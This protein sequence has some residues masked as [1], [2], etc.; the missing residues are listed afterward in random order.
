MFRMLNGEGNPRADSTPHH[1]PA[2]VP[3]EM[4]HIDTTGQFQESRGGS[5]Y[6]IIFVV[7]AF[8]FQSPYGIR[9]KSASAILGV[10]QRFVADMGVPREFKTDS[11][12]EYTNSTFVDYCNGLQI[13]RKL[14]APYTSQQNGPVES[15]LSRAIKAGHAARLQVNKLFPD[16]YFERLKGV[17]DPDGSSVW[18]GYVLWASEGFNRSA[19]TANSGMLFPYEVFFEGRPPI[20]ALPSCKPAYHHVPRRNAGLRV[21]S[22]DTCSYCHACRRA[23]ACIS[24]RRTHAATQPPSI[25]F[26]SCCSGTGARGGRAYAWSHARRNAR[27]E[28]LPPQHGSD[29]PC[30]IGARIGHP[31]GL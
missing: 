1:V 29:A 18:I 2:A 11:G 22:A 14:T 5:R 27:D 7:S 26:R 24:H 25:N 12:A 21:H 16:V 9:D 10:V 13:R 4:V 31:P 20:P 28:G 19:T 17:R 30:R 23:G 8:C 3:I 6:V 15:G